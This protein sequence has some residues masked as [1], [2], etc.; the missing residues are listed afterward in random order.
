MKLFKKRPPRVS[1][2]PPH[3]RRKCC[4]QIMQ[5]AA[6][7]EHPIRAGRRSRKATKF[8]PEDANIEMLSSKNT[9]TK[10]SR[11]AAKQPF[12][13]VPARQTGPPKLPAFPPKPANSAGKKRKK[14]QL[15][16]DATAPNFRF[17]APRQPIH[18]SVTFKIPRT[19]VG[20]GSNPPRPTPLSR[21]DSCCAAQNYS[22]PPPTK[23]SN[24]KMSAG[25]KKILRFTYRL[26]QLAPAAHSSNRIAPPRPSAPAFKSSRI[27]KL[28]RRVKPES[29]TSG[30][31]PHARLSEHIEGFARPRSHPQ[32]QLVKNRRPEQQTKKASWEAPFLSPVDTAPSFAARRV[33][34][35]SP[36]SHNQK[37]SNAPRAQASE[38]KID[39][40]WKRAIA[41]TTG[42]TTRSNPTLVGEIGVFCFPQG[43]CER[44]FRSRRRRERSM[45]SLQ[46]AKTSLRRLAKTPAPPFNSGFTSVISNLGTA[47][48]LHL[49][50]QSPGLTHFRPGC[51]NNPGSCHTT[52]DP[53]TLI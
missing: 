35:A 49:H 18:P 28:V 38:T 19:G 46:G 45:F 21:S 33:N 34:L 12:P 11:S 47:Q 52:H 13:Y 17:P 36:G 43:R 24:R 8:H 26:H 29:R 3:S 41:K 51:S 9:R 5:W 39:F 27:I 2:G 37:T 7:A 42:E 30:S 16:R 53:S 22:A 6:A 20:Q 1:N 4:G 25:L 14:N 40:G 10:H 23:P 31:Q 50:A 32:K 15:R 48:L 44:I